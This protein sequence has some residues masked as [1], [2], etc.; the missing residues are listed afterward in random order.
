MLELCGRSH[1]VKEVHQAIEDLHAVSPKSWSI[2]LMF[3]LPH[4]TLEIFEES[5]EE[6]IKVRP[7]H[8]SC[9]DLQLEEA[10]PFARWYEVG[11]QVSDTQKSHSFFHSSC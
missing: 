9:Y 5:V 2:D 10:T 6:A 3:G 8:L 11:S 7:T 4:Q 1:T